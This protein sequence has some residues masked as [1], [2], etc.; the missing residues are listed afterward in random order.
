M[1]VEANGLADLE[2]DSVS[3]S[4]AFPARLLFASVTYTRVELIKLL[5]FERELID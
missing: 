1:S 5:C 2:K 3:L 4:G